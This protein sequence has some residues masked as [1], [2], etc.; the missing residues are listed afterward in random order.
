MLIIDTNMAYQAVKNL[1]PKMGTEQNYI[2]LGL[3]EEYKQIFVEI[4]TTKLKNKLLLKPTEIFYPTIINK[5]QK[6][7]LFRVVKNLKEGQKL[8]LKN[9]TKYDQNVGENFI[10]G[11]YTL[12]LD[13]SDYILCTTKECI[14]LYDYHYFDAYLN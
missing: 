11:S 5:S 7:I 12:G 10:D 1:L 6:N 13:P 14:S 3:D 8:T 9:I 2:I 4:L